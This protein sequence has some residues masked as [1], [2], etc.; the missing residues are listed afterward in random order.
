MRQL[1]ASI[2]TMLDIR[3]IF[4]TNFA[5]H[6]TNVWFDALIAREIA[7]ITLPIPKA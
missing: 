2:K 7:I 3:F 4:G 6:F 5:N 1:P